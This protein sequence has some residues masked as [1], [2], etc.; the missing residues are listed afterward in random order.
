MS[1]PLLLIGCWPPRSRAGTHTEA[2]ARDAAITASLLFQPLASVEALRHAVTRKADGS[3][4]GPLVAV[5]DIL[6][7]DRGIFP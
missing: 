2:L 1:R 3:A 5:L 6:A 7:S 4:T